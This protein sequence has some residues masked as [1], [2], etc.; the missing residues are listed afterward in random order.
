MQYLSLMQPAIQTVR[1]RLIIRLS[2]HIFVVASITLKE[3]S[4]SDHLLEQISKC[5]RLS[6]IR[7][8]RASCEATTF[9]V[10]QHITTINLEH[11]IQIKNIIPCIYRCLCIVWNVLISIDILQM[12][13][14]KY[15]TAS[16]YSRKLIRHLSLSPTSTH[17]PLE[18]L[19]VTG[20]HLGYSRNLRI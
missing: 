20:L 6:S 15:L 1:I 17:S 14:L 5:N 16:S 13:K 7:L 9:H 8:C 11:V 18:L 12:P 2:H 10:L 19:K 4:V 3:L